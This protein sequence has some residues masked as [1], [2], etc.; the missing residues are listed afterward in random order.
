MLALYGHASTRNDVQRGAASAT[1]CGREYRDARLAGDAGMM[2]YA[3]GP[4]FYWPLS[5]STLCSTVFH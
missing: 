4:W 1:F 2:F 5:P 3:C